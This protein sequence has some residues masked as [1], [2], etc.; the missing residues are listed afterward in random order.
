MAVWLDDSIDGFDWDEYNRTKIFLRHAVS[1]EECEELFMNVPLYGGADKKH[2]LDEERFYLYGS[3]NAGRKLFL[4]YTVRNTKIRV[5]SARD[6]NRKE[7]TLYDEV[8]E[9]T[10]GLQE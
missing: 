6:M 1:A 5:I 9:R 2:S 10:T 7:R 8:A 3:T 4:I